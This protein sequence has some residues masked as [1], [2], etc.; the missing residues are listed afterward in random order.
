MDI[1]YQLKIEARREPHEPIWREA[2]AE[3]ERLQGLLE[4]LE[5]HGTKE[6]AAGWV[7]VPE[8]EWDQIFSS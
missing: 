2:I 6:L 7:V 1:L 3:I 4:T 8:N 5:M